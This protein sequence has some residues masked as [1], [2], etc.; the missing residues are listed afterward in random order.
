M[1]LHLLVNQTMKGRHPMG[2]QSSS[3]QTQQSQT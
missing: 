1:R 3:T 2:G